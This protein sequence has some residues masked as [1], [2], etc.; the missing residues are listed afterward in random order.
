MLAQNLGMEVIAEGVETTEQLTQLRSLNCQYAQG[1]L[2][3]HPQDATTVEVLVE[4]LRL[5][6]GGL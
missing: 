5:S 3:S 2:F 6:S 4:L 1:Y